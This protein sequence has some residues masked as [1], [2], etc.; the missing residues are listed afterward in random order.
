MQ[1]LRKV[2]APHGIARKER[3]KCQLIFKTSG[4]RRRSR[5]LLS[6]RRGGGKKISLGQIMGRGLGDKKRHLKDYKK[7]KTEKNGE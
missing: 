6:P 4:E 3:K 7:N 2:F 1:Q 5:G